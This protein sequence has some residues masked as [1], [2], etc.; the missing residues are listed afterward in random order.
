MKNLIFKIGVLLAGA[1]MLVSCEEKLPENKVYPYETQLISI[2]ILNAGAD[3]NTVMEGTINQDKKEITFPKLDK[4]SPF[5][6][7][8][9]EA[10][11]SEG[12]EITET[13]YDYS[14]EEGIASKTQVIR[15]QNHQRYTDY[16]MT[17][18]RRIPVFGA[19]FETPVEY[20]FLDASKLPGGTGSVSRCADFDG[21]HVLIVKRT[22]PYVLK[23]ED[24]KAGKIEPQELD[25]TGVE[26]GTF[27]VNCGFLANGHIYIASLSG[28]PASPLKIYYY[29]TPSSKPE[30]IGNFTNIPGADARHG[31]M[32]SANI[33]KNGDG[34]IF[35]GSSGSKDFIRIKV[36]G[37]KTT[38]E[39]TVLASNAN[40]TA[41]T[42]VY[43]IEDTDKYLWSG[44]RLPVTLSDENVT[45]GGASL[46]LDDNILPKESVAARMFTFNQERY[47]MACVA[48]FGSASKVT[49]V[50]NVYNL[51]KGANA[52]EAM[53]NF[54]AAESHNPDYS[55]I[56]GGDSGN[57]APGISTNYHIVKDSNGNDEKLIIFGYRMN[58]GFV[59]TEFGIKKEE[60]L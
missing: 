36:S 42:Y 23:Y 3:G 11:A 9:V 20:K 35:F 38:S 45:P 43:R 47:L 19:D 33:D 44:L 30:V 58:T 12:A 21:E 13:V 40:A 14:M 22:P 32:L 51:T 34:Y 57:T 18:K 27:A 53:E 26:G 24:L 31:D 46:P 4:D 28:A 49:P 1:S 2:K 55:A 6:Q 59:I 56:I 41:N 54:K 37:H 10:T 8:R 60:D 50:L 39:P 15:I 25:M 16:F 29:E 17:I 7:L 5:D 52:E 48:K